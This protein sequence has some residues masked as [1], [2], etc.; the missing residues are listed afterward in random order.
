MDSQYSS[1]LGKI[2]CGHLDWPNVIN[3]QTLDGDSV[4]Y[5]VDISTCTPSFIRDCNAAATPCIILH[6]GCWIG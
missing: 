6:T 4:T 3:L 2:L 5:C 1:V